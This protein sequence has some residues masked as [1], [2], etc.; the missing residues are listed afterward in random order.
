[1]AITN[2]QVYDP[3]LYGESSDSRTIP[4]TGSG[5]F[6]HEGAD[7]TDMGPGEGGAEFL[8]IG[9]PA[10]KSAVVPVVPTL[11]PSPSPVQRFQDGIL[12][13]YYNRIYV[14]PNLIQ[15]R[16]PPLGQPQPYSLWN[17]FLEANSL[18]TVNATG[19][20]G[21]VNSAVPA[22]AFNALELKEYDI[23]I[24]SAAPIEVDATFDFIFTLGSDLL[25]FKATRA[26][27]ISQIP[28]VPVE[29]IIDFATNILTAHKG[30]EQRIATRTAPR[31]SF[32]YNIHYPD[33]LSLRILRAQL[34]N[35]L[36]APVV[37]PRWF[38]TF[39]IISESTS[40]SVDLFADFAF[41]D[42][43]AGSFVFIQSAD[44]TAEEL[45]TVS[46]ITDTQ[47]TVGNVLN[48]TY[49]IGSRVYPASFIQQKDNSGFGRY[50]VNAGEFKLSGVGT[51][52]LPLGG[53]GATIS[54]YNSLSLLDRRPLNNSLTDEAFFSKMKIIDYGNIFQT[55]SSQDFARIKAPRTFLIDTRA[56]WQY[57]KLVLDTNVGRRE[58]F[59]H[60]TY[61]KDLVISEQPAIGGTEIKT[62][63]DPNYLTE[64]FPSPAHK[65]IRIE[66]G[67]GDL[68]R[69]ITSA[70]DNLDGTIS[71][72]ISPAL[73][74]TALGSTISEISFLE[75]CRFGSDKFTVRHWGHY[76][77]I[78]AVIRTEEQ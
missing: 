59:Y 30:A 10:T 64:W 78:D 16:N 67:E 62:I 66:T 2:A 11:S 73:P 54:T 5:L 72:L 38:E 46:V 23:T 35:S 19:D 25:V 27:I 74:A 58:P 43:E 57:W 6:R 21:L 56:E 37:I 9:K 55:E 31:Q 70:I 36:P 52:I 20:T 75:L 17:A 29:Q 61:R 13:D 26:T 18:T 24:T 63:A 47:L 28:E 32:A 8:Y 65:H 53:R 44:G 7:V 40:G 34:F 50:P 41:R 33:D 45:Q 3:L 39:P 12:T 71:I 77:K 1:M 51:E 60:P 15:L 4:A 48:N 22:I 49:P 14:I 69:E 76:S 68:Y 42:F